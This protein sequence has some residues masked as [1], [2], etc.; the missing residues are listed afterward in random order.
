MKTPN[1][2]YSGPNSIEKL[3]NLIPAYINN[4]FVVVDKNIILTKFWEKT[5]KILKNYNVIYWDGFSSDPDIKEIEDGAAI[6]KKHSPQC[7]IAIGGGSAIDGA[8]VIGLLGKE[9]DSD[10]NNFPYFIAV[11]T[12]CGTGA[13]S[14]PYAIIKDSSHN[15]KKAIEKDY[16]IP[17]GVILDVKSLETLPK[18]YRAATALDTLVHMI[19][20]HTAPTSNELTRISTRGSL[21]SFGKS[22]EQ[23]IFNNNEE[24]LESLLYIAFTTRLLYP[25]T[26]LSI[27]H[28]LAHPLGAYSGIHHGMI[29]SLLMPEV[30]RFNHDANP[31]LFKET[32]SLLGNMDNGLELASWF[33]QTLNKT[34]I[35]NTIKHQ[36]KNTQLNIDDI[37]A[38]ALESSNIKSNPKIVSSVKD[39][40]KILIL[41]L[42]K[43]KG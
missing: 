15:K 20:V 39:L 16:F 14:S 26:G 33:E 34:G 41:T 7:L 17:N 27:A 22:F 19:E 35:Y 36:M 2:V 28:S 43:I 10:T 25:R 18:E 3:S 23:A 42:E 29:V 21:I 31:L 37:C 12:T 4:I 24:A 30:I 5:I 8:K 40:E 11:P 1:F 6:Y 32:A 13:E 9:K 38:Q